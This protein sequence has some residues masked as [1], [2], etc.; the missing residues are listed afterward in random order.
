VSK[1]KDSFEENLF[2]HFPY[3]HLLR[4]WERV[5][6]E[7]FNLEVCFFPGDLE[8]LRDKGARSRF[9]SL[10]SSRRFTVHA[11]YE[12]I[13]PASKDPFIRGRT[14]SIFR[15]LMDTVA[16][17]RPEMIVFHPYYQGF[18][19]GLSLDS[20]LKLSEE[21]WQAVAREAG[22]FGARIALEN[23]YEEEP[24]PLRLLL[25]RLP[26]KQVGL[27]F[28]TGHFNAFA[29]SPLSRWIDT[30]G[31]RIFEVHLHDN[32]GASDEHL[33]MGRGTFP[34]DELFL[35]LK[36]NASS[37]FLTIEG[38]DEVAVRRSLDFLS[39]RRGFLP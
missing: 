33:G 2:I 6:E 31:E 7:G 34:F 18:S 14:L 1:N 11:P 24:I 19:N 10:T 9:S 32:S 36:K 13:V 23:I 30:F 27:C 4:Y 38:R 39:V 20:W 22:S 15:R 16:D 37:P 25:D 21:V 29:R 28:D 26:E 17:F 35:L 8:L 3:P 12:G 5:K